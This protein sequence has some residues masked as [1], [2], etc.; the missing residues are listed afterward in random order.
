[1]FDKEKEYALV[2]SGGGSRG[3]YQ[4]GVWEALREL[5]VKIKAVAGTS[6]G[7][8]NGVFVSQCDF[9][10]AYNVWKTITPDMLFDNSKAGLSKYRDTAKMQSL[11]DKYLDEDKVR[12]SGVDFALVTFNVSDLCSRVLFKDSIPYGEM[13]EY[14]MASA[15]HPA[16]RRLTIDGDKYIDGG[17]Y[18]NMPIQ[19]LIEKGYGNIIVV[20][21]RDIAGLKDNDY[22]SDGLELIFIKTRHKFH[23]VLDF[24]NEEINRNIKKGYYDTYMLAGR[25]MSCYYY[26]LNLPPDEVMKLNSADILCIKNDVLFEALI[27]NDTLNRHILEY[28]Y[29]FRKKA[30]PMSVWSQEFF[31][32][33]LE[34]CADVLGIEDIRE[35]TCGEITSLITKDARDIIHKGKY[36]D[37]VLRNRLYEKIKRKNFRFDDEDKRVILAALL[38]STERFTQINDMISV[39]SPR[40]IIAFFMIKILLKRQNKEGTEI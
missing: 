7:A 9:E 36:L 40:T 33:C 38:R 15:N 31:V 13:S 11:L 34:I 35:Y 2:L 6:I 30:V 27:N 29:D 16:F 1:M 24:S 32:T 5:G 14:V 21:T 8:I 12:G 37:Q 19:P 4:I 25:Y 23:N 39:L 17:L 10:S 3:A 26:I 22:A 18:N 20:D 28:I